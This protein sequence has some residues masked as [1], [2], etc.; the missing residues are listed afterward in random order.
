MGS[1]RPD[2][3]ASSNIARSYN[4]MAL[5]GARK[6]R[7]KLWALVY[8]VLSIGCVIFCFRAGY[9][10]QFLAPSN[11][12]A[13][14]QAP[15]SQN[16]PNSTKT[17]SVP[18]SNLKLA[19]SSNN[20]LAV[21]AVVLPT[22]QH[23][24]FAPLS[25]ADLSM[26]P[27]G[28]TVITRSTTYYDIYG[29]DG[30]TVRQQI[31]DCGPTLGQQQFT[32]DTMY[33]INWSYQYGLGAQ[34]RCTVSGAKVELQVAQILPRW[35]NLGA[36]QA[37]A[38]SWQKFMTSLQTHENGHVRLDEQY[39]AATLRAMQA[40]SSS[41]CNGFTNQVN[42][43]INITLNALAAANNNYDAATDHG[44]TQGAVLPQ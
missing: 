21:S 42:A 22:C 44:A 14:A 7:L 30:G 1:P 23:Q 27:T 28:L 31:I 16:R 20:S 8:T 25:A 26:Q 39:A 11:Q 38:N 9:A 18:S 13:A 34:G 17:T 32:G 35:H 33:V 15:A 6:R 19:A 4:T 24:D 43:T 10:V 3:G 5:L 36:S 40:A 29:V 2:F 37:F 41:S 12:V